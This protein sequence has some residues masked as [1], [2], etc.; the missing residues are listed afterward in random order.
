MTVENKLDW[1]SDAGVGSAAKPKIVVVGS[2][3]T[4]MVVKSDRIPA[5]GETVTGG[6]FVCAPGGKGANQAVAAARL[7][8]KVT[9]VSR[10]GADSLGDNALKGYQ[11]DRIN[12]DNIARDPVHA[13]GVALIMVDRKGENSISVA[14]GANF[15]LSPADVQA[16]QA[17]IADADVVISQLE[18]PLDTLLYT[19]GLAKKLGVRMILDPAPAPD[20][21]LP[22]AL[23]PLLYCIKPNEHE[24]TKLTGIEVVDFA[25]A[26]QAADTLLQKGVKSVIITLGTQGS[27]VVERAGKGE[28]VPAEKVEAVDTTA[29]GDC[30]SGALAVALGR[31]E[32]L[33][34]AARFASRAAA[35][36]VTRMGAQPS[37][38]TER[39]L[40]D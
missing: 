13:T 2:S 4:D 9:F 28:I 18:T 25:S 22:D 7:G 29:A 5:P 16:A 39:E 35:I 3:N 30:Y 26:Q 10:L 1:G 14:S 36:S 6:A 38:P 8:G 20:A 15:F 32:S 24:A 12:T 34:A 40:N 31:N 17:K 21:P 11:A 27:L 19:S 23:F 37:M 33:V